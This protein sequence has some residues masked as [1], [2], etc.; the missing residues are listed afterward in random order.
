MTD[1]Q[2]YT[3]FGEA[4][5]Y[6]DPDAYVS[7]MALSSMFLP[8]DDPGAEVDPE[9]VAQ[10]RALW[11]V[12]NDPFKTLLQRMGLTQARCATRFCVPLRTVQGWA[13]GERECAPYLRLMMAEATY[14]VNLHREG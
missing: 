12:A 4:A 9:L 3:A 2:I 11:H 6:T 14:A 13:L 5:H 7:D 8:P 1:K 10:L